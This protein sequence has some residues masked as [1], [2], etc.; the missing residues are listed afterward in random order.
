MEP[1]VISRE[2]T[3]FVLAPSLYILIAEINM[4]IYQF[5]LSLTGES[6]KPGY[7]LTN[8]SLLPPLMVNKALVQR[9]PTLWI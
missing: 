2:E 6:L 8:L 4:L 7:V 3:T 9:S 1:H 5:S